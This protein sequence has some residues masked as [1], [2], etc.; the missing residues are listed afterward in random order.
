MP[1]KLES[2]RYTLHPSTIHD[3]VKNCKMIIGES[4]TMASE[5]SCLGIPAMF[6]SNTGRGYTTEQD[7]KYGLIKHYTLN[8]WDEIITTI[9]DWSSENLYDEWQKKRWIMLDD[10]IEVTVVT[11]KVA[12]YDNETKQD[13]VILTKGDKGIYST[14]DRQV[15]KQ[16]NKNLNFMAWKTGELV[17]QKTPLHLVCESLSSHFDT[18]LYIGDEELKE[19]NLTAHYQNK[20]LDDILKVME[21][22][23][24][25]KV[26]KI[27]D[28]IML[29]SPGV[30][31]S[32]GQE[33]LEHRTSRKN[34]PF[35]VGGK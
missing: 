27:K 23:L 15:E 8:Q 3:F 21:L 26:Q 2:Y 25:V 34:P 5:A 10:K 16:T 4:A 14:I 35:N 19:K 33:M 18:M 20:S 32:H 17:F 7:K 12:F 13:K 1:K 6:I 30:S 9:K 31:Q 22:T 11:G 24:H 29:V 28:G